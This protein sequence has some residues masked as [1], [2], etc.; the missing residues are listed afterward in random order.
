MVF[1]GSLME[2]NRR[3]WRGRERWKRSADRL[4]ATLK[5]LQSTSSSS[6]RDHGRTIELPGGASFQIQ[7]LGNSTHVDELFHNFSHSSDRPLWVHPSMLRMTLKRSYLPDRELRD[8]QASTSSGSGSDT[9][10]N[11]LNSLL[12]APAKKP[13]LSGSVDG[14]SG[15]FSSSD[16]ASR[17]AQQRLLMPPPTSVGV[18]KLANGCVSDGSRTSLPSSTAELSTGVSYRTEPSSSSHHHY[19]DHHTLPLQQH[20]AQQ[21]HDSWTNI[22]SQLGSASSASG[23]GSDVSGVVSLPPDG[24][25][26]RDGGTG[27]NV[28]DRRLRGY[29]MGSDLPPVLSEFVPG[30]HFSDHQAIMN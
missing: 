17:A 1:D 14:F 27:E 21:L 9:R 19:Q 6:S 24:D 11:M 13:R 3:G 10:T 20:N 4:R 15:E 23:S 16:S 12:S 30:D 7:S 2:L 22:L 8:A 28:K 18:T 29:S 25:R 26:P 5:K